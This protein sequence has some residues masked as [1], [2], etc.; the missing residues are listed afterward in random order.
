M[1]A[2]T[3]QLPRLLAL[4]PNPLVGRLA[5]LGCGGVVLIVGTALVRVSRRAPAP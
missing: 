1:S 4:V 2:P 3:E 5:F